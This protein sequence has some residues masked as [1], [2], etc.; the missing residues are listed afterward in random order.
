MY[1]MCV[2]L[3]QVDVLSP[4]IRLVKELELPL[5]HAATVPIISHYW[6]FSQLSCILQPDKLQA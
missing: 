3:W 5:H 1:S 2:L 4:V 6:I